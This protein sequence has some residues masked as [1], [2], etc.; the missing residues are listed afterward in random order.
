[1]V[2]SRAHPAVVFVGMKL[3][4]LLAHEHELAAAPMAD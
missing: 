2:V 3:E 1:M 4:C